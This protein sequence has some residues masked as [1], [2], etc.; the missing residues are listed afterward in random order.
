MCK[1]KVARGVVNG[2]LMYAR[3]EEPKNQSRVVPKMTQFT[4]EDKSPAYRKLLTNAIRS[5]EHNYLIQLKK[6]LSDITSIIGK[7]ISN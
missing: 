4:H 7:S 3:G 2:K 1:V 5:T 6:D